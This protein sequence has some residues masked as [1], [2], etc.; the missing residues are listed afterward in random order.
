MME[1]A[2]MPQC[3]CNCKL[4][5]ST[6]SKKAKILRQILGDLHNVCYM[7]TRQWGFAPSKYYHLQTIIK[8]I[9]GGYIG[10]NRDVIKGK[11]ELA[12]SLLSVALCAAACVSSWTRCSILPKCTQIWCIM[13]MS[14]EKLAFAFSIFPL[15]SA[16]VQLNMSPES[17]TRDRTEDIA[18]QVHHCII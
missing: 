1:V 15:S 6:C 10:E 14:F 12:S 4:T 3:T 16:Q 17:V 2:P 9:N 11:P 5:G 8:N 7:S 13:N 18:R